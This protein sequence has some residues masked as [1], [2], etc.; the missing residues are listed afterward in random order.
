MKS[1]KMR[2]SVF[3]FLLL[4]LIIT[5]S[6]GDSGRVRKYKEKASSALNVGH[7]KQEST[8]PSTDTNSAHTQLQ[9][10]TPEGWTENR[11]PSDFRLAAFLV[12][13]GD[14]ESVCTIIPLQGEAGG[15]EANVSRWLGQIAGGKIPGKNTVEELIKSQEKFF[16]K[17]QFPVVLID[18]T[19]VT[20]NPTDKSILAAVLKI[21]GDSVFIKMTGQKSHLVEN[22]I[23]FKALCRS[24]SF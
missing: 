5:V 11:T 10:D 20:A 15:L 7:R 22:K 8:T 3:Y 14:V 16:S 24:F 21:Q 19:P 23:K 18:F 4:A 12:K 1:I 13:T 2:V 9:W 6:C 17:G